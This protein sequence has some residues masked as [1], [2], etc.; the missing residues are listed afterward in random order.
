[1]EQS[2]FISPIM[3][4]TTSSADAGRYSINSENALNF[5]IKL[6]FIKNCAARGQ[7]K[8]L[9]TFQNFI[10]FKDNQ[11]L[12]FLFLFSFLNAFGVASNM[13]KYHFFTK[14]FNYD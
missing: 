6:T 11:S 12:Y 1:M 14:L 3:N 7:M 10:T 13:Q 8:R 5:D 4:V 9:V 2:L